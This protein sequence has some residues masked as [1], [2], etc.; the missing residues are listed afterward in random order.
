ML[1]GSFVF[2]DTLLEGSWLRHDATSWKVAG[3]IVNV[4]IGFYNFP[5]PSN[6]TMALGSTQSL[7]EM[8]TR[9]LHGG[10]WRP[11]CNADNF[12]TICERIV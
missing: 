12:T 8:S 1:T 9:N 2:T 10:K 4:V 6:L 11:A 5:K 3:L 7:I